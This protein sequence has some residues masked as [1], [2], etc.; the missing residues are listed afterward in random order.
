MYLCVCG[1]VCTFGDGVE[2]SFLTHGGQQGQGADVDPHLGVAV[3]L[4][5]VILDHI[6]QTAD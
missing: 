5:G 6:E 2:V 4:P 3:V 1:C